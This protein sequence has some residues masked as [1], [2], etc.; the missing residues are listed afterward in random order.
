MP[1]E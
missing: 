1:K